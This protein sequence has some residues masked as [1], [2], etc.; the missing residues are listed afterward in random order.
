M[1]SP[2]IHLGGKKATHLGFEYEEW[3]KTGPTLALTWQVEGRDQA[4]G[5]EKV[6]GD[7]EQGAG[8]ITS[9]PPANLLQWGWGWG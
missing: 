7:K 4:V 5:W 1:R 9:L 3:G 8:H 6:W 2:T